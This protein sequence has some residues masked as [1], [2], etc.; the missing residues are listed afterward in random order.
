MYFILWK[1]RFA[2]FPQNKIQQA[3]AAGASKQ[4]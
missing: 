3:S 1:M 2:H 4:S